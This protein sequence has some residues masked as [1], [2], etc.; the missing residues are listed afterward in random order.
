MALDTV[1]IHL[2]DDLH[3]RLERMAETTGQPLERLIVRTLSSSLPTLPDELPPASRDALE[4]LEGLTD[5]G[6]WQITHA[7][8]PE[9]QYNRLTILRKQRRD[10]TLSV[11]D[12]QE[13]DRL[14]EEADLL[15]LKKAYAAVLL[16]WRGHRLPLP[17]ASSD[18]GN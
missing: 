9:D 7:T 4:A 10:G 14:L 5:T 17:L 13:L 3:R 18:I 15:T 11:K 12:Q 8:F 2:P 16:R 1:T 6:L